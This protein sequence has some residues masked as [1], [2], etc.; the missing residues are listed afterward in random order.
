MFTYKTETNKPQ[1]IKIK[2]DSNIEQ[3]CR[4]GHQTNFKVG[5]GRGKLQ[6]YMFMQKSMPCQA[7]I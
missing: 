5:Q 2:A 6:K 7:D 3:K 1:E 4:C